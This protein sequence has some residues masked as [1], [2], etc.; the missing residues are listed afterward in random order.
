[1]SLTFNFELS[2]GDTVTER[3]NVHGK[4]PASTIRAHLT[5]GHKLTE[6]KEGE[7]LGSKNFRITKDTLEEAIA[8]APRGTYTAK[9]SATPS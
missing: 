1:M 7:A 2:R 6:V 9:P 5:G 8:E 4:N 3:F